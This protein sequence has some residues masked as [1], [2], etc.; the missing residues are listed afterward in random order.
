MDFQ[1][2]GE[3]L[4]N[5][6]NDEMFIRIG[7]YESE[8]ITGEL[9][10]KTNSDTI[11]RVF[12]DDSSKGKDF[13]I[14]PDEAVVTPVDKELE[15]T[16]ISYDEVDINNKSSL[17]AY[18]PKDEEGIEMFECVQSV[19]PRFRQYALDIFDWADDRDMWDMHTIDKAWSYFLE[20]VINEMTEEEMKIYGFE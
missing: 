3:E 11:F 2:L 13:N 5:C 8:E 1:K 7:R 14:I 20:D 4:N 16:Q 18:F 12:S 6:V 17:R 15:N 9:F 19:P 10:V